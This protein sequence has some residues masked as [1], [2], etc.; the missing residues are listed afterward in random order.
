MGRHRAP[1]TRRPEG[2]LLDVAVRPAS[3][4]WRSLFATAAAM[5]VVA[6]A[7]HGLGRVNDAYA[8]VLV[9]G[10]LGA[11]GSL[12]GLLALRVE[13]ATDPYDIYDRAHP[14]NLT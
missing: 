11:A 7:L 1:A 8:L 12:F 10:A 3:I 5:C 9:A 4:V 2:Q 14:E 13:T 6:G